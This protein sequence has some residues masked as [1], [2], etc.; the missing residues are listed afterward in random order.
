MSSPFVWMMTMYDYGCEKHY[1]KPVRR[2]RGLS[3]EGIVTIHDRVRA[4][5]A[6][7]RGKK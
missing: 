4:A 7:I 3:K 6:R 5:E 2:G 1:N